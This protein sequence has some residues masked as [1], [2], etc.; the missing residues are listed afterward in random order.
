M[1]F[2]KTKYLQLQPLNSKG[3]PRASRI[4]CRLNKKGPGVN[5]FINKHISASFELLCRAGS[6]YCMNV[7]KGKSPHLNGMEKAAKYE[8][9]LPLL[10]ESGSL[11]YIGLECLIQVSITRLSRRK[12]IRQNTG[13][14]WLLRHK[15]GK[16][17]T[18][19]KYDSH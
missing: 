2:E 18:Y 17:R 7:R 19:H 14:Q 1:D 13:N 10:S 11:H 9:Y 3:R 12:Q 5:Q 6:M 8:M 4:Q 16:Q 15:Q